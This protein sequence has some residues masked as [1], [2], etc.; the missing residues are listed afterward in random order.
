M[1]TV[2]AGY[3]RLLPDN[4][5]ALLDTTRLLYLVEKA[6]GLRVHRLRQSVFPVAATAEIAE[7]LEIAVGTPLIALR[8]VYM[9]KGGSPIETSRIY[10]HPVNYNHV[11][12]F[13]KSS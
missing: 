7:Q 8:N 13:S 10:C 2:K 5:V 1:I 4:F 11:I 6:T 3:A 9:D 12:E